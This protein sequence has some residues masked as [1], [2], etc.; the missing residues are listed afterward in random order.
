MIEARDLNEAIR[1]ASELAA[2]TPGSI[3]VRP[4]EDAIAGGHALPAQGAH[5][6]LEASLPAGLSES[7]TDGQ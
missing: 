2:V 1:L 6:E 5:D 7:R 3:E 4:V